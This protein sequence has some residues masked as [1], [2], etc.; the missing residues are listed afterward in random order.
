MFKESFYIGYMN[1]QD[2]HTGFDDLSLKSNVVKGVMK[3]KTKQTTKACTFISCV[4]VTVHTQRKS[5][6]IQ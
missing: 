2:I 3:I 6:M 1:P 4:I 5:E